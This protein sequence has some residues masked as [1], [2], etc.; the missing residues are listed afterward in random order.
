MFDPTIYENLK[1]VVEGEIYDRDLNGEIVII[2]RQDIINLATM[3][4]FYAITFQTLGSSPLYTA[5]LKI[6][7]NSSDLYNEIL[8]VDNQP[9]C[10][11]FLVLQGPINDR[12]ATPKALEEKLAT[13]WED[14][15][16][17]SQQIYFDWNKS[18][19]PIYYVK[20]TLHFD[21]KV[22]ESHISDFPEIITLLQKSLELF[23]ELNE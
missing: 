9:G 12:Y 10:Q 4:R 8:E 23:E 21:R 11:L 7:A 3:S 15:P 13:L 20:T 16:N 6:E 18:K 19:Q 22:D 2:D 17:I 14:R 5:T 1:V